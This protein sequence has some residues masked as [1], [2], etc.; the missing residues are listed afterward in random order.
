MHHG[1]FHAQTE[2]HMMELHEMLRALILTQ[3]EAD[4][5]DAL[6]RSAEEAYSGGFGVSPV[7]EVA[8][9]CSTSIVTCCFGCEIQQCGICLEDF[10][11]GDTL[12]KLQ[13]PHEFHAACVDQWLL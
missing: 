13:C 5:Q 4:L 6:Q 11:F 8:L 1:M 12:R 10:K 3:D 2:R 7:D 9:T